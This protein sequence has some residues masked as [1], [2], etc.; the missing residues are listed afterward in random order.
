[1]YNYVEKK[2]ILFFQF[3]VGSSQ[4]GSSSSQL[5][6]ANVNQIGA[7]GDI[8]I[9]FVVFGLFI[10]LSFLSDP[11]LIIVFLVKSQPLVFSRLEC[12]FVWVR[13][14]IFCVM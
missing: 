14:R 3:P 8:S 6:V 4:L 5:L 7:I 9:P 13:V 1:M 11:S 10:F 12:W 2:K